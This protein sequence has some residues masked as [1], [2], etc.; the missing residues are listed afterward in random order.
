MQLEPYLFFDGKCEEALNFYKD[1]FGGEVEGLSRWSEM[2]KDAPGPSVTP[3]TENRVMHANFQSPGVSFM[4][5]DASPGKT[6]GEGAISL[7]IGTSDAAE[8]E[9][10]FNQ[11]AAGGKVEMPM[12]DMFWGARFGMLTDKFGIDWMINCRK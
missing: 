7:S 9:R 1:V 5:S 11:L 8:A 4:A 10:V 6:Y 3:E 2:P 12:T